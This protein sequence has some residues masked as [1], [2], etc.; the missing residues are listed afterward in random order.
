MRTDLRMSVRS[1]GPRYKLRSIRNN[2]IRVIESSQ[3]EARPCFLRVTRLFFSRQFARFEPAA[4]HANLPIHKPFSAPLSATDTPRIPSLRHAQLKRNKSPKI[5]TRFAPARHC[6][7]IKHALILWTRKE[8]STET[9][10]IPRSRLC[11]TACSA[12]FH[13]SKNVYSS[14]RRDLYAL[15]QM[16]HFYA[17]ESVTTKAIGEPNRYAWPKS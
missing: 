17:L 10:I 9:R 3:E 4:N 14:F 16:N 11:M 8:V 15:F 5:P 7:I 1:L 12:R 6:I 2:S 13:A